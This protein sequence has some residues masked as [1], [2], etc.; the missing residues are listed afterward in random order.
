[1]SRDT[2]TTVFRLENI[3]AELIKKE[4]RSSPLEV[5]KREKFRA[6]IERLKDRLLGIVGYQRTRLFLCD[7]ENGRFFTEQE[8]SL[9]PEMR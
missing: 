9:D 8:K 4:I 5:E 1:M 7:V 6:V 3:L 2:A